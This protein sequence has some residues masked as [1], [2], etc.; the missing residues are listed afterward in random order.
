MR[1]KIKIKVWCLLVWAVAAFPAAAGVKVVDGDSLEIDGEKIRLQGIDSPEYFQ[2][3][4]TACGKEYNCGQS[5]LRYLQSVIDGAAAKGEKVVCDD[6][7]TDRYNRTLSV[8][9]AG[10]INLNHEMVRTGWATAYRSEM[11]NAAE[12]EAKQARR[13]IWQGK[14]MRPELY[15]IL[16]RYEKR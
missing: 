2:T 15:R 6:V 4:R 9:Y 16:R 8:C 1:K 7:G 3:C 5:A 10:K 14:F 11:Y 12:D 13:G